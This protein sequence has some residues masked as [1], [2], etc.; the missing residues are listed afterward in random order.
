MGFRVTHPLTSPGMV[1]SIWGDPQTGLPI[2]IET[3]DRLE[4]GAKSISSDF[5]F[6]VELDE[7]LFNMEPPAGYKVEHL[8]FKFTVGNEKDIVEALRFFSEVSGG[9]FP[10]DFGTQAHEL[11][12]NSGIVLKPGKSVDAE[13]RKWIKAQHWAGEQKLTDEQKQKVDAFREQAVSD[14]MSQCT[15]ALRFVV[16]L[17]PQADVHYAGKGVKFGAAD[18]PIFWYRP[19]NGKKYRVIYADLSVRDA[20]TP[21]DV[22]GAQPMPGASSPK[23]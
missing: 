4:P 12:R 8:R 6:N 16:G 13:V 15:R 17:L 11:L 22:P 9:A 7:S 19:T 21:P 20:D 5:V 1:V 3:T 14:R 23:K 2:R 18:K 10:N